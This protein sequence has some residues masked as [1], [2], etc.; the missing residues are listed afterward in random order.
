MADIIRITIKGGSGYCSVDEAY[1]DKLTINCTEIRYE[2]TPV[3]ESE[4][5]I[6]RKWVYK[7]T[8]PVFQV[9]YKKTADVAE[10]ILNQE[11]ASFC[12]DI[13]VTSFTVTYADKSKREKTFF[14]PGDYFIEC[15]SIIKQM[16]PGCE[17]IPAVLLTSEDYEDDNKV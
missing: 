14:L 4:T 9:L 17:Y 7:T 6:H 15:Y 3:I 10:K 5:N 12:T 1:E 8:S 11:N 16:I 13:G 2:Y